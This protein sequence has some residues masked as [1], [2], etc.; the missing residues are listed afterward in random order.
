MID[1]GRLGTTLLKEYLFN[2]TLTL[3]YSK[4]LKLKKILINQNAYFFEWWRNR[5]FLFLVHLYF[6]CVRKGVTF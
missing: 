1:G 2:T 3:T 4:K 5:Y 6:I